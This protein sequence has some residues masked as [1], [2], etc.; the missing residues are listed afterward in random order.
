MKSA[1]AGA[2]AALAPHLPPLLLN[3]ALAAAR[4]IRDEADRASVMKALAPTSQP[5]TENSLKLPILN[6]RVPSTSCRNAPV[7]N[8]CV[9][10]KV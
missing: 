8:F 7:L 2:L 4:G 1:R 10:L 3:E 9:I 6:G 5:G